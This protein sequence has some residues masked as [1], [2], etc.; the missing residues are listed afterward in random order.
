[1]K[2]LI[3]DDEKE[4]LNGLKNIIN[5]T[6]LG[7][8]E[9]Y[10]ATKG[11]IALEIIFE[12]EPDLILIDI[13]MPIINGLEV[14]SI[15]RSKNFKGH[16]IIISG[17]SEFS[18]AQKAI[19]LDVVSYLCKPIDEDELLENVENIINKISANKYSNS[20]INIYEDIATKEY[21]SSI[22]DNYDM[23]LDN[24]YL[25]SEDNYQILAYE[26]FYQRE[27][28]IDDSFIKM[29]SISNKINYIHIHKD[30]LNLIVLV[31]SDCINLLSRSVQYYKNNYQENSTL[32]NSFLYFGRVVSG[33]SELSYS[34]DEIKLLV[35]KRF[36]CKSNEH[37]LSYKQ[38]ENK[39]IT[40]MKKTINHTH[41]ADLI[42]VAIQKINI[43]EVANI[44]DEV[45]EHIKEVNFTEDK[46]KAYLTDMFLVIRN[47]INIYYED[48][49]LI[50]SS[51][52]II[53]REIQEKIFLFEI[54]QYILNQLK[55][56]INIIKQNSNNSIMYEIL[57]FIEKNYNKNIKLKTV[58][59]NFNYN[60][61]YFGKLFNK[62]FNCTFNSYLENFRIEKSKK[63]LENHNL[64]VY[65]VCE[66]V[67]YKNVDYFHK[68][69]KTIV[70]VSPLEYRK[71]I[72]K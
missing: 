53:A 5:W 15:S 46:A 11:D 56:I 64:K 27:F 32:D 68:K 62:L 33:L 26:K 21:L 6:S 69:F 3:C 60:S 30:N 28:N 55:V 22:L 8:L 40:N 20:L 1:M 45:S 52:T 44:L 18:Y 65:E 9:I 34:Y 48:I 58:A 54:I 23:T 42:F 37:F 49:S 31:G 47:K 70:G 16:F 72:N 19:S 12:I 36:F 51:F 66:N 43:N 41:F 13:N 61:S 17:F 59:D 63:L 35:L 14:I 25:N 10:T 29:L 24:Y 38:L 67:G 2:L 7:F 57:D 71:N 39:T 50:T 4:I